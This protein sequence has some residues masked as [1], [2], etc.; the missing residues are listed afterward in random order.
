M[1]ISFTSLL[2]VVAYQIVISDR[3]PRISDLTIL[4]TCVWLSYLR[5]AATIVINLRVGALDG[6]VEHA[7]GDRLDRLCRRIFPI[8]YV[9]ALGLTVGIFLLPVPPPVHIP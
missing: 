6:Q 8:G 7:R 1:D 2:T 5:V 4:S 9:T 3:L